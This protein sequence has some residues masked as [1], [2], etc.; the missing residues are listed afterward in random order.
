M[1]DVNMHSAH[2]PIRRQLDPRVPPV[3]RAHS[4][5]DTGGESYWECGAPGEVPKGVGNAREAEF[6]NILLVAVFVDVM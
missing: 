5:D 2:G 6:G 4:P 3:A 1:S